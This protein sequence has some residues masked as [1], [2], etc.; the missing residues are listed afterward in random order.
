MHHC[1]TQTVC[2]THLVNTF[3][4]VSGGSFIAPDHD[5]PS[6]LEIQLTATDSGG[7][8]STASV[9]VNPK[10]VDLTFASNPGGLQLTVGSSSQATPF[11]RTVIQG[12]QNT[13]SAPTPQTSAGV[14]YAFGSWSDGGAQTHVITAPATAASYT[15]TYN[16]MCGDSFGNTCT[17]GPRTFIPAD[18][19]VLSLTGDDAFQQISMPFGVRLYGQTYTTG[20]VDTNGVISF[21]AP[22]GPSWNHGAIPSAPAA[23]KPNAAVYPFWDDLIVDSSASVRTALSG[24]APNRQFVVE[25]RNVRFFADPARVSFEVVFAE[26]GDI[27][28]AW[29][30]IDATTIEQGGSATVGIENAAGTVALQYSLN[31]PILR[32]GNG[33]LFHPPAPGPGLGTVAGTVTDA[34]TGAPIFGATVALSPGGLTA[35]S[36]ADGTYQIGGVAAGT[37]TVTATA[38]GGQAASA[39]VTVGSGTSTVNLAP[40][41]RDSFGYTL[42]AGA[43]TWLPAD[44][45][46]LSLTGDDAFQQ[47][48]MPF[49]VRLYGQ[50]YT[51]GWVDT[52]GVISFVAPNGSSWNHGAIPSAPAA[53][54]PNAAVYPF[55]TDLVVDSSASVRTAVV[56]TAPN[57]QFVVEWRNVRFFD[58]PA[59]VSFE[60]VFSE[61]GDIAVAWKDID[62]TTVEQGGS[63]TVGIENA[64]GTVA[65]QYSLNKP[66]IR[67][68]NGVL[69][70]PPA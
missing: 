50:T 22:N 9:S 69:F 3:T 55:W 56:G 46:V 34:A 24:T 68:G 53:N 17:A 67:T 27:A 63:A 41:L 59:R 61:N 44:Q 14:T 45:T 47:I 25:W 52:N 12:S 38:P 28:V 19:T 36:A 8:T 18:Q 11:T 64:A 10:T 60:V 32:T 31:N 54:K 4:G 57:R 66:V 30:D 58:D 5:Y 39:S 13:V 65:L 40:T 15:A 23:N 49:G 20:W 43:R 35:T 21:V 70:R 26:N 62:A 29:K 2:H 51:T 33:V 42:A 48:S 37:Y 1:T 7:L 16:S 6:F